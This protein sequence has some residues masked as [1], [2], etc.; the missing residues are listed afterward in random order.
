[1]SRKWILATAVLHAVMLMLL[2]FAWA[3]DFT[4]Q[5]KAGEYQT[6]N[7]AMVCVQEGIEQGVYAFEDDAARSDE[8]VRIAQMQKAMVHEAGIVQGQA[9]FFALV[10]A[11]VTGT[12]LIANFIHPSAVSPHNETQ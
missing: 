5:I 9:L 12:M 3:P 10:I 7:A 1:M 11:T 4:W 2:F 8:V 6:M